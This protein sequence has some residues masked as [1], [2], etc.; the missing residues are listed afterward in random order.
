MFLKSPTNEEENEPL[1][2]CFHVAALFYSHSLIHLD[3][4]VPVFSKLGIRKIVGQAELR[5]DPLQVLS[6]GQA[7]QEV[8]LT[9]G[10]PRLHTLLQELQNILKR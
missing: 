7:A 5:L 10:K 1:I 2:A 9:M 8:D 6:E 4:A 3:T